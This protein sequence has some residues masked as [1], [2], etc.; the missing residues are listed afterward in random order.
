MKTIKPSSRTFSS[1]LAVIGSGLAGFAATVFALKRGISTCQA[2]STGA[3]AYTTG[4]FDMLGKPDQSKAIDDPWEGLHQLRISQPDHPLSMVSDADIHNGFTEFTDFLNKSGIRY[5]PVT[6]ANCTAL[7]PAGTLKTTHCVPET[8]HAGVEAL[9]ARTPC[10]IVDFRGLKGFS[11]HQVVANLKEQWPNLTTLRLTFPGMDHGEIYPEVM[12]RAL[13]VPAT[14]E[15]LATLLKEQAGEVKCIG[16]PAILGMHEP[17]KVRTRLEQLSGLTIF[18]I[19]TMP[20]SVPGIR[21]REMM[22]QT[23]PQHGITLIP[24]QKVTELELGP[25]KLTLHLSDNYG[26]ITIE[27][28]TAILATGR[29]LSGGLE[30]KLD[31]IH[32]PLLALP[33][34]QPARREDWFDEKYTGPDGHPIHRAGITVDAQMRPLT[35]SGGTVHSTRLFSAGII[36]AGQDWIRQRCGAGVAIATAYRAVQSVAAFLQEAK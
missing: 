13:E 22:E 15:K 10:I 8:M 14:Q 7:S 36:L 30:A 34:K 11:G 21:L 18:E 6:G 12:A 29:F 16:M 28:K 9:E 25:D 33:V 23:L 26:P 19:P 1:D 35:A 2:G 4:Y 32:E 24:Q 3:I 20:P 5:T 27:A 31:G 17:D